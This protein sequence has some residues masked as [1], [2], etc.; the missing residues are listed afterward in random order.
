MARPAATA[1]R[2]NAPAS[3]S[4][5][6]RQFFMAR[7]NLR[8]AGLTRPARTRFRA[9]PLQL[10]DEEGAHLLCELG[11]DLSEHAALVRR[12]VARG[13]LAGAEDVVVEDHA[14]VLA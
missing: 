6:L 12:D 11:R 5:T 13:G 14:P 10:G 4:A 8:G 2:A 3:R 9:L 1:R 7:R